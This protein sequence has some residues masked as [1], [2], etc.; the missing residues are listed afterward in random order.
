VIIR[1]LAA[2]LV[3]LAL[4]A[5]AAAAT[6]AAKTAPAQ[7]EKPPLHFY[8]AQGE[9]NACGA[10]CSEWIAAEGHFDYGSPQ[11]LRALL[12][13]HSRRKLPIFFS[14]P[15][16]LVSPALAIGRLMRE[17]GMTAGVARTI[18]QGCAPTSDD[19]ACRALK[20]SGKALLAEWRSVGA[21]CNSSCVYALL[22]AKLRQVP[23]G[24]RLGVHKV[25]LTV[26]GRITEINSP[27]RAKAIVS[28]RRRY[29]REMGIP[30][31]LIEA[32]EKIPFEQVHYL[33]RDEI[34]RFGIDTRAFLESRWTVDWP[35]DDPV[36]F[37]IEAKGP[38]K[39]EFR[40]SVI[41]L[42]CLDASWLILFFR[43]L[44]SDEIDRLT[45][46]KV[47]AGGRDLVHAR[48]G[49]VSKFDAIDTG[50]TF[51]TRVMV[52]PIDFVDAAAAGESLDIT[53]IDPADPAFPP[54]IRRLSTAGLGGAL[55]AVRQQ[56]CSGAP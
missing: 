2:S 1:V 36:K 32:G 44:A 29:L 28:K 23:P 12:D 10:G 6:K 22:G 18:P 47:T 25:V 20:H 14:S 45:T 39:K 37:F 52:A 8:L 4:F 56:Q 3:T 9:N 15:G 30:D 50:A 42:S 17:R 27:E 34:A 24:A 55:E 48:W 38:D 53:E 31:G 35:F 46:I 40:T 49:S 11:R 19:D 51:D 43:G 13:R 5:H 16:G 21:N 7:P 26:N 41:S 33:S 54:R